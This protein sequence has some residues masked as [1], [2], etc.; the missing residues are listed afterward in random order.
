[1]F[2][3]HCIKL[4]VPILITVKH[5]P[6]IRAHQSDDLLS[7]VCG[8]TTNPLPIHPLLDKGNPQASKEVHNRLA[9]SVGFDR[10]IV[11]NGHYVVAGDI[12][13]LSISLPGQTVT[14]LFAS[15]EHTEQPQLVSP[16]SS[17][18]CHMIWAVCN[19]TQGAR[20]SPVRKWDDP[21]LTA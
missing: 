9:R 15:R 11:C 17:L 19:N 1:M 18:P 2:H 21:W 10:V 14:P 8:C 3:S 12:G 7:Q 6:W 5:L 20:A 13:G 4:D 16:V